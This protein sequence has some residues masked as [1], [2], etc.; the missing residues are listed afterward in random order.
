MHVGLDYTPAIRQ[1]GGIGRLTR[2]LVQGLSQVDRENHYSLLVR[3]RLRP[4]DLPANFRVRRLPISDRLSHVVWHR[5]GMPLAVDLFTGRLDLFHSLDY[6]LPPVRKGARVITVHDLTFLV[7]PQYAEPKLARYLARALPHSIARASLVLADSEATRQD[8]LT[9]LEVPPEKVEVVYAGVDPSFKRVTDISRLGR[10]REK[11][12]LEGPFI[13]NVGTLE[14]RKN[15]E[16][17]VRA[18]AL[19][20]GEARLPHRLALAGGRG[21]LYQGLFGLVEELGLRELVSFL[22]YVAEEDLPALLSLAEAFVYP[23][24]YEGFG[25]PP[26]EAMACGAP[27]VAST[28][29]CLP[30]VLGEAALLVDPTDHQ[31][32]ASA[33]LRVLEDSQLRCTLLAKGTQQAAKY[34]WTAAAERALSLYRRAVEL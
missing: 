4:V 33:V 11:Y 27:V 14:P 12:G 10:V 2:G 8:L 17:L 22:G 21:W 15:L 31:A 6:L 20:R 26:L 18:F 5:M 16:G 32:L 1:G 19:L 28:A 13:L 9:L 29:P 30:E 23:S 24:F 25:L 7:V 3:G 34:T